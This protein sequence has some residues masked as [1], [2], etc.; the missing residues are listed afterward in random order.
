MKT[1]RYNLLTTAIVG[2]VHANQPQVGGTKWEPTNANDVQEAELLCKAGYAEKIDAVK[3]DEVTPTWLQRQD[4][5]AKTKAEEPIQE[6]GQTVSND[7]ME[8]LALILDGSV[9]SVTA[10]L[11]GLNEDELRQLDALEA[12]GKGRKGVHEAIAAALDQG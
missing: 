4:A 11:D 7:D 8:A 6:P 1:Q 3:G 5:L 2:A 10:E 12:A 9:D